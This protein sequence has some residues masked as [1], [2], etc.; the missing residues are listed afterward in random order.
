MNHDVPQ[1]I[2]AAVNGFCTAGGMGVARPG[3]PPP[4]LVH[5]PDGAGPVVG[6]GGDLSGEMRG[7]RHEATPERLEQ[8]R[9]Q[10]MNDRVCANPSVNAQQWACP[11]AKLRGMVGA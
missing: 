5:A 11:M 3:Q 8:G 10:L 1:P 9:T 7:L 6:L 4:E 2:V